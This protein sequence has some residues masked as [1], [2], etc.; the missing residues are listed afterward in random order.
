MYLLEEAWTGLRLPRRSTR[1]NGRRANGVEYSCIVAVVVRRGWAAEHCVV[2]RRGGR[3]SKVID[4]VKECLREGR[5]SV[6]LK[7]P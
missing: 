2:E 4:S 6:V 7:R 5:M 1:T 3:G